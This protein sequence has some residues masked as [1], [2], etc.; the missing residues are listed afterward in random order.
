VKKANVTS[1]NRKLL[2]SLSSRAGLGFQVDSDEEFEELRQKVGGVDAIRSGLLK[3]SAAI[4]HIPQAVK[5]NYCG[6]D[7]SLKLM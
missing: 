2:T 4:C 5:I 3:T 6:K 7:F 1:G